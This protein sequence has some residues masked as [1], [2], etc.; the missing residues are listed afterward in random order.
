MR[1]TL[2]WPE[3]GRSSSSNRNWQRLTSTGQVTVVKNGHQIFIV[4]V[5]Q[6]I[7]SSALLM[8]SC[9]W[10]FMGA[11]WLYQRLLAEGNVVFFTGG[12]LGIVL[13]RRGG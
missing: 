7:S 3:R 6:L 12:V 4:T 11:L 10:A 9:I 1:L 8:G 13:A 5:W 2:I